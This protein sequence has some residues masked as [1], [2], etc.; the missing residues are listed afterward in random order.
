MSANVLQFSQSYI[1]HGAVVW[2][3]VL[4][5]VEQPCD[6]ADKCCLHFKVALRDD[7]QKLVVHTAAE[8][9]SKTDQFWGPFL[10]QSFSNWYF[11]PLWK[12]LLCK[13]APVSGQRFPDSQCRSCSSL[14]FKYSFVQ[15]MNSRES[16]LDLQ[17]PV[18]IPSNYHRVCSVLRARCY[19]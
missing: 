3:L 18:I 13:K 6:S 2:H 4:T 17:A 14:I 5:L 15:W 19:K 10:T 11:S 9:S 12:W 7:T 1:S 16:Y 8:W